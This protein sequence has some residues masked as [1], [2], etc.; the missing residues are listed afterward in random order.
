MTALETRPLPFLKEGE[1]HRR[2]PGESKNGNGYCHFTNNP[3]GILP[4]ISDKQFFNKSGSMLTFADDEHSKVV[5]F[6]LR[7]PNGQE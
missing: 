3:S 4:P 1:E 5:Y 6:I 2:W 7:F